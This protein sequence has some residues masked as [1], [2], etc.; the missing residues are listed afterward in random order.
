MG[1]FNEWV[2]GSWLESW[3]ERRVVPVAMNLLHGAAVLLRYRALG[4]DAA[5]VDLR[6]EPLQPAEIEEFL[7]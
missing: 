6:S 2:R 3:Q 7:Q 5:G 4:L 1:A